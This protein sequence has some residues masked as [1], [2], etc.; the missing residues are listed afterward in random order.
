MQ[1]P[2]ARKRGLVG[3]FFSRIRP[4]GQV[5]AE[6]HMHT[7]C[8]IWIGKPYPSGYAYFKYRGGRTLTHRVAFR[9]LRSFHATYKGRIVHHRCRNRICVNP[10]HLQMVTFAQHLAHHPQHKSR[11]A[12]GRFVREAGPPTT[13]GGVNRRRR[14]DG[15]ICAKSGRLLL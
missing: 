9:M 3:L 4:A 10:E 5:V 11:G 6:F 14:K 12:N 15:Q 8:W 2:V 1:P 13:V 7:A